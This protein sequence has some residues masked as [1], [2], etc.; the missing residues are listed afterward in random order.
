VRP[1]REKGR[2]REDLIAEVGRLGWKG[3]QVEF[4]LL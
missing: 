4:A 3:Q 2:L 1:V